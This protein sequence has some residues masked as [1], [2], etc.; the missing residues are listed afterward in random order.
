MNSCAILTHRLK[1]SQYTHTNIHSYLHNRPRGHLVRRPETRKGGKR[2]RKKENR[3]C[4]NRKNRKTRK[5][6][7][8]YARPMTSSSFV[9]AFP[10]FRISAFSLSRLV[11]VC[12][13]CVRFKPTVCPAGYRLMNRLRPR[14]PRA[15][16][17]RRCARLA[18]CME[19]SAKEQDEEFC[20]VGATAI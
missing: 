17:Q 6:E 3:K 4:G 19:Q 8:T 16:T 5:T 9:F 14:P 2:K 20:P 15:N 7:Q 10:H 18:L 11:R 1:Y 12:L 13:D